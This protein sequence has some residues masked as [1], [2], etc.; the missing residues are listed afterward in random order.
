MFS[1]VRAYNSSTV[2]LGGN[3]QVIDVTAPDLA[4]TAPDQGI[5]AAVKPPE[6]TVSVPVRRSTRVSQSFR[7]LPTIS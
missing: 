1:T 3:G 5:L 6:M 4:T 2:T 7:G